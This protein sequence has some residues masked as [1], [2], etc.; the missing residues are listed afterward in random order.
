MRALAS[1]TAAPRPASH[2]ASRSWASA[3]IAIGIAAYA[4]SRTSAWRKRYARWPA[5]SDRAGSSSSTPRRARRARPP[6]RRARHRGRAPPDRRR[7]TAPPRPPRPRRAAAAWRSARR[8][9]RRAGRAARVAARRPRRARRHGRR[10]A[11]GTAGCPAPARPRVPGRSRQR[12]LPGEQEPAGR[13]VHRPEQDRRRAPRRP[14]ISSSG[15]PTQSARTGAAIGS[16]TRAST[17]SSSGGSAQCASS[18]AST[19]GCRRA[20]AR[21]EHPERPRQRLRRS[22]PAEPQRSGDHRRG[23]APLVGRL[24]RSVS[25]RPRCAWSTISRNG[26]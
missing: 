3:R 25:G 17:R 5:M 18:N 12:P 23:G 24:E 2:S 26:Q 10:A 13:R 20:S 7:G 21:E 15:R 16:R 8:A 4:A 14:R 19:S 6:P 9:A 22:V 1:G 11:P